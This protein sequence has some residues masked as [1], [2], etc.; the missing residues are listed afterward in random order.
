[1]KYIVDICDIGLVEYGE[2]L[3]F[4]R[5]LLQKRIKGEV[6]DT[7]IVVEHYPVVT[8][9][10]MDEGN[11]VID[12]GYFE[13]RCIPIVSAGR[14][15]KITY[16]GSGQLVLYPILD[17][18]EKRRDISFYI[19]FLEKTVARGLNRVGIPAERVEDRR[20]V[21]VDGK[22]IAFIG[23]GVKRWVT[24]HGIAININND[25]TPF[26]RID[27]CGESDIEVISAKQVLG[28]DVDMGEVKRIFTDQF[29]EDL[30]R[31]YGDSK[32]PDSRPQTPDQ[33][34]RARHGTTIV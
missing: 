34:E 12:R 15:G 19:D 24:Y 30:G 2:A 11:S 4:Q 33:S 14:G 17:L 10:R 23:I 26:F 22:K 7:L 21:W 25:I 6:S 31:E 18:R 27:P 20:G 16:H 9:G 13:E 29:I 3:G 5:D 8:L 32:T 28:R 1:M